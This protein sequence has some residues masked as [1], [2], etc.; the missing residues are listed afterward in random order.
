M[1]AL[2]DLPHLRTTITTSLT[3]SKSGSYT[4]EDIL[5]LLETEQ[6]LRDADALKRNRNNQ[7]IESTALA[8][9]SK[10]PR[11]TN[12]PTCSLCKRP[13]H[14][15]DYCVMP[16]GGMAGKTIAES[17][18]ARKMDR[19]AKKGGGNSNASNP[20]KVSVTMKWHS[21]PPVSL[22]LKGNTIGCG[23]IYYGIVHGEP[24]QIKPVWYSGYLHRFIDAYERAGVRFSLLHFFLCTK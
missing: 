8:A 12:V 4:F 3:N 6:S 1:N 13:G 22:S 16:G 2:K 18:A 9:Q 7:I 11:S 19:E 17:I 21:S 10:P 20:G 14:T 24:M 5:L 15:N 23:R